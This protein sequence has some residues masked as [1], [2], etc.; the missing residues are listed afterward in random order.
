MT[1]AMRTWALGGALS[2]ALA[3]GTAYS[4]ALGPVDVATV[5]DCYAAN[6]PRKSSVLGIHLTVRNAAGEETESRF[7]LYWR[8]LPTGERRVMI[9]F[10]APEALAGTGLLVE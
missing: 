3:S 9:R 1:T 5:R 10:S 6:A 8:R 7:K 4:A 2:S